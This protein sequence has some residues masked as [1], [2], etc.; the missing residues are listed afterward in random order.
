MRAIAD[1]AR[2]A[3]IRAAQAAT[4][5]TALPF[6]IVGATAAG[7]LTV[8]LVAGGLSAAERVPTPVAAGDEVR[9][10]LYAVT[11]IDAELTDEVESEYFSA[12]AG[13]TLLVMTVQIENLSDRPIGADTGVNRVEAKLVNSRT[14]LL[15][16]LQATNSFST[17]AWRSDGS[18]G[19]VILQPGVPDEVMIAWAVPDD[20]FPDGT[21]QLD[22]FD[23]YVQGGR[24]ILSSSVVLW[25]RAEQVA[26]IT[27]DLGGGA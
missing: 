5:R 17:R 13:E 24:V 2:T 3:S 9:T 6:W 8:F 19:G 22:V 21:V 12:D 18:A 14:P 23:A 20:A 25:E 1:R 7:I 15:S 11:V 16:V 10:S 26:R 4:R 27:V